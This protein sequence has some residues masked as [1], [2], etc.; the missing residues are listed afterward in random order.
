M[1]DGPGTAAA[2]AANFVELAP[3]ETH[4]YTFKYDPNEDSDTPSRAFAELEMADAG[5]VSFEVWTE[6]NVRN[7]QNGEEKFEDWQPVGAGATM[8]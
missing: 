6:E 4:W 5:D 2:P 1:A 7:W 3:G 8:R